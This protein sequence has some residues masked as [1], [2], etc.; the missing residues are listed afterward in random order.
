MKRV[1]W[2]E[3]T[4]KQ[5]IIGT[6]ATPV[7]IAIPGGAA[8]IK[9]IFTLGFLIVSLAMGQERRQ[10][11]AEGSITY[12]TMDQVYCDL[13]SDQGAQ[14]GD[15]LHVWRRDEEVGLLVITNVAR[16]SSVS[17][18]LNPPEKFQLGDRVRL[19]K[20][21]TRA[22]VEESK[23]EVS[24]VETSK[25]RPFQ[26]A[27]SGSVTL[28]YTHT[29]FSGKGSD[30]RGIGVV[31]YGLRLK[32]VRF[33]TYGRQNFQDNTFTL[34]QA[35]F[36]FGQ[37]GDRWFTQLGRVY[38]SEL[39][40]IGASDGI[41][42]S[43]RVR[44][45]FYVGGLAGVQPQPGTLKLNT[46][47]KKMGVFINLHHQGERHPTATSL[48]YIRQMAGTEVDRE[49]VYG[50][51]S[52][53]FGKLLSLSVYQTIDLYTTT[54][55]LK[56]NPIEFTSNQISLR[57]RPWRSLV[58]SSRYS[59]RKRVLYMKADNTLPDSLF[60]DA[61]RYGFYNSIRF[62]HNRIG[63]FSLGVN[64]RGQVRDTRDH[65]IL[66]FLGYRS[67]PGENGR[68]FSVQSSYIKN[69]IIQGLRTETGYSFPWGDKGNGYVE[70]ELYMYGFGNQFTKYFQHTVSASLNRPLFNKVQGSCSL[71]W[72]VDKDY[73]VF[74]L[75]FS[76][77]YR[78]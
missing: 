52:T 27:Q 1:R 23:P 3:N 78:L 43:R 60:N 47:V 68:S 4:M 8:V 32:K 55:P 74:Y 77:N 51:F 50:K 12:L 53:N 73:T 64:F 33:W 17:R 62:S 9:K 30:K 46:Q 57:F 34:Y 72:I 56:R 16:K 61:M 29:Q 11:R 48:A 39:A 38:T 28:R 7:T 37:R 75:Y 18:P 35:R 21:V 76:L 40:G 6:I 26:L 44:S 42:F 66:A 36:T 15:T 20:V 2:I 67:V 71:D 14:V 19:E 31:Q 49:F 13:G 63:S 10:L 69:L 59:G 5:G 24:P 22:P 58:L 25:E 54:P 45:R 70:Y 65:A 41:L